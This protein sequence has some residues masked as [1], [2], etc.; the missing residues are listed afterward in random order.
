MDYSAEVLQRFEA[1]GS[2]GLTP[3][4]ESGKD[5]YCSVSATAEDRSLNVWVRFTVE[6]GPDRIEVLRYSV[7]GCPHLIA[8]ADWTAEQLLYQSPQAL[9]QLDVAELAGVLA[10]PREKVG[11]LL[12]IEDALLSCANQL[13]SRRATK[14]IK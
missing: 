10:V 8:A 2:H 9:R 4:D 7:F 12:R 6:V 3:R 1:A 5:E 11:K 14:E 13:D